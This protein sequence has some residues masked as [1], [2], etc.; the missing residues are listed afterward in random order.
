MNYRRPQPQ[1]QTPEIDYLLAQWDRA[2]VAVQFHR[3]RGI[4]GNME[5]SFAAHKIIWIGEMIRGI[6]L[7]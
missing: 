3:G 6:E 5:L 2:L 1:K 4:I 7:L